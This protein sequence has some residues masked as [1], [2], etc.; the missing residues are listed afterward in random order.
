MIAV[1]IVGSFAVVGV[2]FLF[3][4][5]G[6][7][8]GG[9]DL[10]FSGL[11]GSV[12]VVEM[13]GVMDEYSGRSVIRQLERW[14]DN[15]SIKAI[16]I[17]VESP[18]G[19]VSISQELYETILGVRDSKPVVV[20][21]GAVAASGGYYIACAADRVMANPGTL[22]GSI[23]TVMSFHTYEGLM[24]KLGIGMETIK[25][26]ELKDVG[27]YARPMTKREELMLRSVIMDGYEQFVE[28]VA[29]GRDMDK[30]DVYPLADGSIFTGSQAY[31][32]GLVDTLGGLRDAI[33][34]AADLAEME[35]E[36]NVIRPRRR[37]DVSLFDLLGGVLGRLEKQVQGPQTGPSLMYLYQ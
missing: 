19:G 22:T 6:L 18:G 23:G 27:T 24:D 29:E 7:M 1:I 32:L 13:F 21:M 12:A 34:L 16:V 33:D 26:G 20:S 3:M 17:H 36:P 4:M 11:G 30:E 9:G 2:F 35:G 31:N 8:S 15:N 25:S 5:I 37:D 10:Q 28:V 14:E